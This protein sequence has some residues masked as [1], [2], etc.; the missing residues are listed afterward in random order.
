[1]AERSPSHAV[2]VAEAEAEEA[3]ARLA[4][5]LEKLTSPATHEAMKAELMERVQ[6]Y[7]DQALQYKDNLL[8]QARDTSRQKMQDML[9]DMKQRA[10]DNPIAVLLIGAGIGWRLYKDPPI[11]T[12][13]VGAGA[14]MLMKGNGRSGQVDRTA[15]RDP[16][17]ETQ[18]RGYVPGGVAGYG[19][20]A[21]DSAPGA[22]TTEQISAIASGAV[23]SA[24]EQARETGAKLRDA[25]YEA[26]SRASDAMARAGS[27]AS[28]MMERTGTEV[29]GAMETTMD[30]ASDMFETARRNP[31]VLG[32]AGLAA[33]AA[34]GRTLRSTD[35][36]DRLMGGATGALGRGARGATSRV[37]GMAGETA[38]TTGDAADSVRRRGSGGGVRD[39][40]STGGRLA[41]TRMRGGQNPRRSAGER[42]QRGISDFAQRYPLLL[43]TI[44]LAVGALVGGAIRTTRTEDRL[45]GPMMDGLKR[46]AQEK[47]EEHLDSVARAAEQVMNAVGDTAQPRPHMEERVDVVMPSAGPEAATASPSRPGIERVSVIVEGPEGSTADKRERGT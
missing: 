39:S 12:V 21:E 5:T 20:P 19:Y 16:Y 22:S 37:R 9:Q 28:D 23:A 24:M 26:G 18:P 27:A 3:R 31:V 11:T 34:L 47:V 38:D 17:R 36:G 43:G 4:A 33:G 35:A 45:M 29:G 32:A 40:F 25:A 46:R 15:Y 10:M 1:M 41:D 7:K 6:G 8:N 42:V 14:A 44:G 2:Q 30:R 13:L